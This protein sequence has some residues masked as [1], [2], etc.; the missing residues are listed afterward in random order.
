MKRTLAL[1][2]ALLMCISILAACG[3]DDDPP[4]L[5]T[6]TPTPASTPTPPPDTPPPTDPTRIEELGLEI[7]ANGNLRFIEQREIKVLAWDRSENED[8]NTAFTDYL[9]EQMLAIHNVVITEFVDSPRWGEEDNIVLLL[10]EGVA[11]DVC[12]TYN[13]AGVN[14]FAKQGAITDL[15]PLFEDSGDLFPNLWSFLGGGRLYANMDRE[16]GEIWSF[17]S[18]QP[19][20]QRYISF[21]REDWVAALGKQ[22]PTNIDEFEALLYAFKENAE[23]LLGADASHMIPLHM[24]SDPGWVAGNM[25]VSF[26]P[27]AITDK[28]IYMYGWGSER[29][30]FFPGVKEGVRYLNKWFNDGLMHPDFA[31]FVSG[32]DTADNLVKAGFVG[33]IASHSFDQP[34]RNDAD[35]WNG[36]IQALQGEQANYIAIDTF[37]ND[38]GVYRKLLGPG[39]DRTLFIPGTSTEPIAALM[40]LDMLCRPE[41]RFVLQIGFEG[42]N[43]SVEPNG[44]FRNIPIAD[45]TDPYHMRSGRNHDIAIVTHSGGLN[46]APLTTPEVEGF[47]FALSFPLFEPRLIERAR[48]VQ[49]NGVRENHTGNLGVINAEQGITDLT[50]MG[51]AVFI[52]AMAASVADFDSVYDAEMNQLLSRYGNAVIAERKA[53]WE[54]VFGD[55]DMLPEG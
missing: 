30:W 50:D 25:M 43:Y 2:L 22:L 26:V 49:A 32:D 52:R 20:N 35:G 44:A 17:M 8:P 24:T 12:V 1:L 37:K 7:D 5:P 10:A 42:I 36:S 41:I 4:V 19:F 46:L 21:I 48:T 33:A 54:R 34:Y 18:R 45:N 38:A 40:Y 16:T 9:A 51:N 14:E 29:N 27:D 47:T 11:P 39:N 28:E 55:A 23:L 31:L 6:P 3:G 13:G 15:A 53:I